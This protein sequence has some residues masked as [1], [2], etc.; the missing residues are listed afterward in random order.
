MSEYEE[1]AE[2]RRR[3]AEFITL[4]TK[5]HLTHLLIEFH[6]LMEEGRVKA[7]KLRRKKTK[8]ED[9]ESVE[10]ILEKEKAIVSDLMDKYEKRIV[11]FIREQIT[12]DDGKY[13]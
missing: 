1:R 7:A 2:R 6:A 10:K 3:K 9:Q 13:L 8:N 5:E 12:S 4:K 11:S